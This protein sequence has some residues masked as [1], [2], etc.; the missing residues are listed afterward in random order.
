MQVF[1]LS[2]VESVELA[3]FQL[4]ASREKEAFLSLIRKKAHM[5][6][7]VD[8]VRSLLWHGM[9]GSCTGNHMSIV[10]TTGWDFDCGWLH[11]GHC[12]YCQNA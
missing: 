3:K 10:C 9:D 6:M 2:Y 7:P 5:V 11:H 4:S 12:F 8:D 1:M